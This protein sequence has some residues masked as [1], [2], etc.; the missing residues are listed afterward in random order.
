MKE[1]VRVGGMLP[2]II[3][4]LRI[5]EACDNRTAGREGQDERGSDIN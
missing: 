4:I 3:I 2:V 5:V 1:Q